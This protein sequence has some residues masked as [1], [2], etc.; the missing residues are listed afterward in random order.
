MG[1][2]TL[3]D[4]IELATGLGLEVIYGDTDSLFIKDNEKINDF[5]S[6]LKLRGEDIKID[7]IFRS[8]LFTEAK[9]K[10]AGI[11]DKNDLVLVGLEGVRG[12]APE[13]IKTVQ[14]KILASIL[15]FEDF[16]AVMKVLQDEVN[17]LKRKEYPLLSFVIYKSVNK[18]INSYEIKAP[19]VEAAKKY[20]QMGFKL[21]SNVFGY[22]IA[23]GQGPINS[24]ALPY[25]SLTIDDVDI[26]YYLKNLLVPSVSRIFSGAFQKKVV[27]KNNKLILEDNRKNLLF[28]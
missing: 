20:I 10:Y 28:N 19:H 11:N 13:I 21:K 18:K 23:N 8:I 25:F 6:E 2:K 24:R 9:K 22:V 17:K 5:L 7:E 1:R 27:F 26:E 4:A 14:E 16:D 12:D 15:N 3:T